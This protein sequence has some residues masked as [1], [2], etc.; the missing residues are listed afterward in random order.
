MV[1]CQVF[2]ITYLGS[3]MPSLPLDAIGP[4][5]QALYNVEGTTHRCEHMK[6]GSERP[7]QR[8]IILH[9]IVHYWK[10]SFQQEMSKGVGDLM[11]GFF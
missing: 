5:D 7:S 10:V 8:L 1:R 4:V 2:L 6:W 3:D 9:G 11:G